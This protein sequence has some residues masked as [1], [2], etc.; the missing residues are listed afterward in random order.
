MVVASAIKRIMRL[1]QPAIGLEKRWVTRDSLGQQIDGLQV[2]RFPCTAPGRSQKK[3]FGAR[4]EIEGGDVVC[5]GT[6]D[7][8][9]FA[10]RKFCLQLV[11][12]RLCDLTLNGEHVGEIAIVR[13]RPEVSVGTRIDQLRVDTHAIAR[14]LDA[15]FQK[16]SDPKL[17]TNLAQVAI[18]YLAITDNACPAN[19]F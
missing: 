16:M 4:V 17:L 10:W 19:D 13:L 8:A 6:F 11:G 18:S 9:F 7:C 5:R 12:D 1:C 3:I 14:A 2:I 15:S